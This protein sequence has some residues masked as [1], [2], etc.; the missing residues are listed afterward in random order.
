LKRRKPISELPTG[1]LRSHLD[2]DTT[3]SDF[4]TTTA[5]FEY[6]Y[7]QQIKLVYLITEIM[8]AASPMHEV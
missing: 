5:S 3:S 4:G 7:N 8:G 6:S 1:G 2:T